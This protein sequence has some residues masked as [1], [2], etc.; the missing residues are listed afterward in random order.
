M[1]AETKFSD[2]HWILRKP[3]EKHN[4]FHVLPNQEVLNNLM[5]KNYHCWYRYYNRYVILQN[6][7]FMMN[8]VDIPKTDSKMPQRTKVS[9]IALNFQQTKK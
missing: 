5:K 8:E 4:N 1:V 2:A 3:L 7:V 6:M 9:D